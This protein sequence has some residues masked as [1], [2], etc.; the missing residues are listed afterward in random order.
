MADFDWKILPSFGGGVNNSGHPA[1]IRD[2][3]WTTCSGWWPNRGTAETFPDYLQ[4]IAGS[5]WL[6]ASNAI[7]GIAQNLFIADRV[8]I[9]IRNTGTSAVRLWSIDADGSDV[10]VSVS[11][12]APVASSTNPP[13]IRSVLYQG[14]QI[15]PL[16][17]TGGGQGLLCYDGSQ[18]ARVTPSSGTMDG[19]HL[20]ATGPYL[21]TANNS[22]GVRDV[23]VSGANSLT[24]WVPAVAN[25][26]DSFTIHA[27]G[28]IRSAIPY[29]DGALLATSTR[30]YQL[31]ATGGIPPFTVALI[32]ELSL[33]NVPG[34]LVATPFGAIQPGLYDLLRDGQIIPEARK[35]KL[36]FD[37][38]PYKTLFD[39]Q[40]SAILVR[41]SIA[42]H[43]FDLVEQTWCSLTSPSGTPRDHTVLECVNG[44][45]ALGH[46]LVMTSG[47]VYRLPRFGVDDEDDLAPMA[48]NRVE[49]KD[50]SFGFPAMRA[51]IDE[52]RVDWDPLFQDSTNT[53]QVEVLARDTVPDGGGGFL[54]LG[55]DLSFDI[56]GT[57]DNGARSVRV[58]RKGTYLR[59]RFSCIAGLAR[60]RGI[61]IRWKPAND[62]P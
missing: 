5:D 36:R 42:T 43:R 48:L 22:N 24:T 16:G 23:N 8:L 31:R 30:L 39:A 58:R 62:K 28:E 55:H 21:I 12:T 40:D 54:D 38:M 59:V 51:Y 3:E 33:S 25:E 29:A 61:G 2:D 44:D 32:S 52:I 17:N 13:V 34:S 35:R 18:F 47:D 6:P 37:Q 46:W 41:D 7:L 9:P 19:R 57:L 49:T 56:V 50:L 27:P 10:E 45:A 26:A 20:V 60:I 11:G 1:G 53:L 15:I 14:E 4:V